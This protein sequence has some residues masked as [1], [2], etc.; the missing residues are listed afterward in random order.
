[1]R[2]SSTSRPPDRA[3]SSRE[4][5]RSRNLQRCP[6]APPGVPFTAPREDVAY[7]VPRPAGHPRSPAM[8]DERSSESEFSPAVAVAD[9]ESNGTGQHPEPAADATA[10]A[11]SSVDAGTG[12]GEE[13]PDFLTQL[14][15]A[16]QATAGAERAR[17]ADEIERRRAAHVALLESRRDAEVARMRELA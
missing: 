5:A 4:R 7:R 8:T 6:R 1:M 10:E 2:R 12:D 15:R 9:S 3:P 14:A 13:G 11:P 16:M 17:V